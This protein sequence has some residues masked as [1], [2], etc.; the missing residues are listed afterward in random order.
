MGALICCSAVF[1]EENNTQTDVN[2]FDQFDTVNE[3]RAK[4]WEHCDTD[5]V[6]CKSGR[7]NERPHSSKCSPEQN[8]KFAKLAVQ[9][10]PDYEQQRFNL[11]ERIRFHHGNQSFS[12]DEW[13]TAKALAPDLIVLKNAIKVSPDADSLLVEQLEHS[14]SEQMLFSL[15]SY[16][17]AGVEEACYKIDVM[18]TFAN[19]VGG[20]FRFPSACWLRKN[21]IT[22]EHDISNLSHALMLQNAAR[23]ALSPRVVMDYANLRRASGYVDTDRS[24][25]FD[26]NNNRY[27]ALIEELVSFLENIPESDYKAKRA[28]YGALTTKTNGYFEYHN[29]FIS[30]SKHAC[31]ELKVEDA[32]NSLGE[33]YAMGF[34]MPKN[35]ERAESYFSKAIEISPKRGDFRFARGMLLLEQSHS[36]EDYKEAK[37]SFDACSHYYDPCLDG[38]ALFLSSGMLRSEFELPENA[39]NAAETLWIEQ[40]SKRKLSKWMVRPIVPYDDIYFSTTNNFSGFQKS[41]IAV[42]N[43]VRHAAL[44]NKEAQ[45]VLAKS[46]A[47]ESVALTFLKSDLHAYKWLALA[48]ITAGERLPNSSKIEL[49]DLKEKLE[50]RMSKSEQIEAQN[51]AS[52]LFERVAVMKT[53]ISN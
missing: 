13:E 12:D 18:R 27:T 39:I 29:S 28:V 43:L 14:I 31:D 41:P 33:A 3:Q 2:P 7:L 1:A 9:T 51:L 53:A 17:E 42:G 25:E 47:Q 34:S 4:A 6:L 22:E 50:A 36:I 21:G 35:P 38:V 23:Q 45:L 46:Y 26:F 52:D 49:S 30:A 16:C 15:Y 10:L 48:S 24:G 19:W 40:I 5:A 20:D 44:G 11:A 8:L 37:K 32:C